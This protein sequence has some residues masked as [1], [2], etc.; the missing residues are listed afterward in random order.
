MVTLVGN[1]ATQVE[2]RETATGGMA[3]FRLAVTP[4]RWD[5]R[6]ETW[7][8][9]NTSFYTVFAW[10]NLAR[11]LAGS[12]AVGEPLLVHGRLRVRE[13]DGE[14]QR[15]GGEADQSWVR[16]R[17]SVEVEA[18][19]VGHDLTRGTAAFRRAPKSGPQSVDQLPGRPVDH[20]PGHAADHPPD[21]VADR[22][23]GPSVEA[24]A[25][26][27][28][29]GGLPGAEPEAPVKSL[30]AAVDFRAG[31]PLEPMAE[32]GAVPG[33][34]AAGGAFPGHA[35]EGSDGGSRAVEPPF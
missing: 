9:G 8:D 10:R 23:Q 6:R 20:P 21:T 4:R 5:R 17:T 24:G 33:P 2:F 22:A 19:S 16:R 31:G 27:P 11:N 25:W 34:G 7:T 26:P 35:A 15:E 1:A 29:A 32:S 14:G 28:R 18:V 3:R 30:A 12:V 13:G